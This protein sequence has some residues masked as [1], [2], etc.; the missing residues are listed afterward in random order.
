MIKYL[1]FAF[2]LVQGFCLFSQDTN[3]VVEDDEKYKCSMILEDLD[4][5]SK[6][7]DDYVFPMQI[8]YSEFGIPLKVVRVGRKQKSKYSI[9]MVGN[10]HARE[11]YSSKLVMKFLNLYLMSITGESDLYPNAKSYLDSLDIY[12]FPLAN[13]DGL[14]IAHED[15]EGIE[16][17]R[18]DV[19][20]MIIKET[21]AEWKANGKG[22][23]LNDSFDDGN[24]HVKHG[25]KG[26]KTPAS[27]DFKGNY[28]AEP[29]ETQYI[30]KFVQSLRPLMTI[31]YHTK[32]DLVYWADAKTHEMFDGLDTEINEKV[33]EI[34]GFEEV[35]VSQNPETY[36][37][38]LE[39]YVRAKMGLPGSCVELSKSD[40]NRKQYADSL[41][42]ELVWSKSNQIP[43]VYIK[44]VFTRKNKILSISKSFTLNKNEN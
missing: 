42:N 18:Y 21:F 17:H 32:G 10:I 36:G 25:G 2:L 41:F 6:K 14:K 27:E 15:W 11:D 44:E 38:G 33:L 16:K 43:M 12:I 37:C 23:D 9:L 31:S 29:I 24:H 8:G 5:L 20:N 40:N 3:Y 19:C 39:N 13:P 4:Y 35:G 30:Q 1:T 26:E 7:Y 22:I 34:S 28:P